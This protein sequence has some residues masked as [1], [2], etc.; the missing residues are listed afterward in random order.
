MDYNF[1]FCSIW[2][3]KV[4]AVCVAV[5]GRAKKSKSG[6]KI[7]LAAEHDS[8]RITSCRCK[9]WSGELDNETLKIIPTTVKYDYCPLHKKREQLPHWFRLNI[10]SHPI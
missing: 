1:S 6:D 7:V 2:L 4:K 10:L 9:Y 5:F 8:E 3:A